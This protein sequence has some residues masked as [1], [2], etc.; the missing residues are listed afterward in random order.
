MKKEN[1]FLSC[2]SLFYKGTS[3]NSTHA[4]YLEVPISK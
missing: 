3:K 2:S 4:E 1:F